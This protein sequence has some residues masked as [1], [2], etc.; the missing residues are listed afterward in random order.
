MNFLACFI[1]RAT[2]FINSFLLLYLF[3]SHCPK[4][5]FHNH[6]T[7]QNMYLY[8]PHTKFHLSK[9]SYA[10]PWLVVKLHKRKDR[11]S[12]CV[13]TLLQWYGSKNLGSGRVC[14]FVSWD[15]YVLLQAW[16]NYTEQ[17]THACIGCHVWKCWNMWPTDNTQ[18]INHVFMC[19]LVAKC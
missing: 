3:H 12:E 2:Q 5:Q 9:H 19:S 18:H 15:P 6:Q 4:F 8:I 14:V 7:H 11:V 16:R 13:V 1:I 17:L 10:K